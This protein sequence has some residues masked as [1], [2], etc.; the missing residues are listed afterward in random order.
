MSE[1]CPKCGAARE[2]SY[3]NLYKCGSKGGDFPGAKRPQWFEESEDCLR[4][5]LAAMTAERDDWRKAVTNLCPEWVKCG[6]KL[7]PDQLDGWAVAWDEI[8]RIVAQAWPGE[9][10]GY[11]E[12]PAELIVEVIDERDEANAALGMWRMGFSEDGKVNWKA[13]A[14]QLQEWLDELKR[15]EKDHRLDDNTIESILLDFEIA[16]KE[17]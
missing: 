1:Q 11:N 17:A 7:D 6:E 4:R 3:V 2:A 5:Q 14:D 16:R 12:S 10:K 13:R 15:A 8:I 9:K